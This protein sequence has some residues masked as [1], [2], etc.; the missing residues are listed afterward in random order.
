VKYQSDPARIKAQLISSNKI[1]IPDCI[2]LPY[3]LDKSTAGPG[4]GSLSIAFSFDNK[5]IKLEV[6]EDPNETFSL[7]KAN[8]DF[9]IFK[10]GKK[11][12]ENIKI[13]PIFFHAPKQAFFNLEDRCIYNCAFCSLPKIGLLS[14]YNKEKFIKL[15]IK[16]TNRNDVHSIALTAGVYPNNTKILEKIC[17]IVQVI[18]KK[19]PD[20]SIGVETCIFENN[21]I[22]TLKNAGADEIK[23][24]IQIPDKILFEK[25][26][27]EFNH[28]DILKR[29]KEAVKIFG[30][31]KVTSNIIYGLGELDESVIQ[32][33]EKLAMMGVVPT[34]RKLRVNRFN[35]QRLEEALTY[36]IP[37]TSSER[38]LKLALEQKKIFEKYALSTETF[39]TMCHKCGCCDIV[40]FF[41]V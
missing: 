12:L 2:K 30:K 26:C 35:R 22:V 1:Y 34:L 36:E 16:A 9:H 40:P 5:N 13:I 11:F 37:I 6:S 15:I 7:Q 33:I 21:E 23:I 14:D 19:I 27:P 3:P 28:E 17:Y 25:I 31:G 24:N 20:V 4:S 41:D 8:N 10:K 29:L 18:S 39:N 32:C 38:I